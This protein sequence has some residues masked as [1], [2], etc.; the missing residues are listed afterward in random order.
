[1]HIKLD[2]PI[3]HLLPLGWRVPPGGRFNRVTLVLQ[4]FVLKAI[5]KRDYMLLRICV[6]FIDVL[7][8]LVHLI[9]FLIDILVECH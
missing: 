1:V 8:P 2:T 5:S 3:I 4:L 9:E 7:Q 6:N